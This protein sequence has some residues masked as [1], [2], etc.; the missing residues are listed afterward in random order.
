MGIQNLPSWGS[1]IL[2][3]RFKTV[4]GAASATNI[5]I[6]GIKMTDVIMAAINLTDNADVSELPAV[7]S[8]GNIQ[9]PTQT[10]ATKQVLII[11]AAAQ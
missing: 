10:T 5:A 6:A 4:A 8:A 1:Q 11:Y 2:R 7:T 9:F 3:L